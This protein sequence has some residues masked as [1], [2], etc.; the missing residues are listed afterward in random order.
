M[1]N[2]FI[3]GIWPVVE[4]L[5][6]G[7]EFNAILIQTG[8]SAPQL[9]EIRE[10]AA[11]FEVPL[12][13]VPI[14]KLNRITR[15]NHQGIV[16][17]TS[18]VEY[19]KIENLVPIWFEDGLNPLIVILDRI[20]DV[21]NFGAIARSCECMGVNAIVIPKQDGVSVTADA[22]R[23]SSGSL[24]RIPVCRE[25]NLKLTVEFLKASGFEVVGCTEK[26]SETS[27]DQDFTVPTALI[28]GSEEKGIQNEIMRKCSSLVKI[29]MLGETNS[30]N[31]SVAAGMMLYEITRQRILAENK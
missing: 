28:M 19:Q 5:R 9:G 21:R 20:T 18:P 17:L 2:D 14:Q 16:G 22:V 13:H 12:K 7:K 3:F 1:E 24:N 23:T 11:E 31:V 30:L 6:G 27:M 8:L 4:A 10:L 15:K 29:P 25:E 26:A